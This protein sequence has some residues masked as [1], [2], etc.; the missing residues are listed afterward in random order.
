FFRNGVKEARGVYVGSL[1][2]HT[3]K[4]VLP[5]DFQGV[6]APAHYL[7]SARNDGLVFAQHFDL[8]RLEVTGQPFP[9]AEGVWSFRPSNRLS[10]SATGGVLAYINASLANTEL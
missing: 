1:G 5:G 10:V 6:F 3:T 9:V 4:L 7:L 2:S 8:T